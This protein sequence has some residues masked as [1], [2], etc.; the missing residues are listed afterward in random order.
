VTRRD[1]YSILAQKRYEVA[2]VLDQLLEK[3]PVEARGRR[4]HDICNPG[5]G[6]VF[7]DT[8]GSLR[9]G[10][11]PLVDADTGVGDGV[12]LEAL[13]LRAQC[14]GA[15]PYLLAGELVGPPGGPGTEV[16]IP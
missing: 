6:R 5:D 15:G 10:A 12:G 9:G 4:H 16:G 8:P 2:V 13:E 1:S 14:G 7:L 11:E 3:H